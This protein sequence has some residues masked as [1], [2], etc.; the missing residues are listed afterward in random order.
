[1]LPFGI[2]GRIRVFVVHEV[3]PA[4]SEDAGSKRPKAEDISN[5]VVQ[6]AILA[7]QMMDSFMTYNTEPLLKD[8]NQKRARNICYRVVDDPDKNQGSG[9]KNPIT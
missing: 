6:P 5:E 8:S 4:V 7:Q 9:N 1:M 3:E 2:V